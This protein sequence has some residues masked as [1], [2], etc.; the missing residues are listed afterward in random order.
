MYAF[1]L[2]MWHTTWSKLNTSRWLNWTCRK[3][4]INSVVMKSGKWQRQCVMIISLAVATSLT[5]NVAEGWVPGNK[6]HRKWASSIRC[7]NLG[8]KFG[9][10]ICANSFRLQS[11]WTCQNYGQCVRIHA[12]TP[13]IIWSNSDRIGFPTRRM[14]FPGPHQPQG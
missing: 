12:C 4:W 10:W 13:F 3:P 11:C 5:L 7:I 14:W 6:Y 9:F 2:K 1:S 8:W